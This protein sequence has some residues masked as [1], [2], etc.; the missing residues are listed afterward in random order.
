MG[1]MTLMSMI[2][3]NTNYSEYLNYLPAFITTLMTLASIEK[4]LKELWVIKDTFKKS[5]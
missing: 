2:L 3:S 4:G 5:F 1:P